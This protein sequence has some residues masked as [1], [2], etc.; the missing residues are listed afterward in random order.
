M[1]QERVYQVVFGPHIS[2]KATIV[3]EGNS[4]YV[5]RVAND[6]SKLE[7][8]KAV[9]QLFE[10]KVDCVRTLI[11]KGK[12]KRTQ[13]GV[14]KRNDIKKAYVRLAAGQEIDFLAAE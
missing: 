2:E 14:G 9:E 8:K 5:F 3:A 13:R 1:N 12:T 4:Q 11:Q 6:A 7:I 10:V